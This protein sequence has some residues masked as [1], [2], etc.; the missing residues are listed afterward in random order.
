V[1]GDRSAQGYGPPADFLR[2]LAHAGGGDGSYTP[3]GDVYNPMG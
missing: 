1:A 3:A 2:R